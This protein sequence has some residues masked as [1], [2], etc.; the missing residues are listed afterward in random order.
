MASQRLRADGIQSQ[1]GEGRSGLVCSSYLAPTMPY[2][3]G[4]GPVYASYVAPTRP[5]SV[6]LAQHK[7]SH[8][9]STHTA[10]SFVRLSACSAR[11]RETNTTADTVLCAVT[12]PTPSSKGPG[13]PRPPRVRSPRF[14]GCPAARDC[15]APGNQSRSRVPD[16]PVRAG[17]RRGGGVEAGPAHS[18]PGTFLALDSE[19]VFATNNTEPSILAPVHAPGIPYV[20]VLFASGR[21]TEACDLNVVVRRDVAGKIAVDPCCTFPF[22][23]FVRS[24]PQEKCTSTPM[25]SR[26]SALTTGVILQCLWAAY[27]ARDWAS[28]NDLSHHLVLP[29]HL[30]VLLDVPELESR[31]CHGP[32][33]P[34][35]CTVAAYVHWRA[36]SAV[37]DGLVV[38]ARLV[39]NAARRHVGKCGGSVAAVA[40]VR[41]VCSHAVDE[42]LRGQVHE[43]RHSA[44]LDV[45]AI[46]EGAG[47]SVSPA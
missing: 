45:D 3:A 4:S 7:T 35:R 19:V 44:T 27:G 9:T 33:T 41:V 25:K 47:R 38:L 21:N 18:R 11:C 6:G 28:R 32:A 20:P 36:L 12:S 16:A 31:L 17:A 5:C 42:Y 13:C 22:R 34:V 23:A 26:P 40:A 46:R 43:W 1:V 15:V 10:A 29:K 30:S 2:S 8:S 39:R 14:L 24:A 37:A